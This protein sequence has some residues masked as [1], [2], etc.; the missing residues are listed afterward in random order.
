VREAEHCVVFSEHYNYSLDEQG[1]GA[2]T[3]AHEILHLFGAEDYY[4]PNARKALANKTYPKDIMLEARD[5]VSK[6]DIGDLTAY[7]IGWTDVAP[8]I[9]S[10]PK[11]WQ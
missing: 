5:D 3:I 1:A 2:A 11:W 10:N 8:E 6:N 7:S 9:C 4:T